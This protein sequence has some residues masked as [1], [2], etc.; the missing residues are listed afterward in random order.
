MKSLETGKTIAE[1]LAD[2]Y[3]YFGNTDRVNILLDN[4]LKVTKEDIQRV[5]QK[6]LT[7]DKRVVLYY[8]PKQ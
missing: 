6:Y 3:V 5:A 2:N 7:L 1:N 4:Y 8:L